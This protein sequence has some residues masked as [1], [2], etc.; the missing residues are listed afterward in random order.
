MNLIRIKRACSTGAA[1]NQLSISLSRHWSVK[2]LEVESD[3]TVF[4]NW[5][6]ACL[7][8]LCK[9]HKTEPTMNFK[10]EGKSALSKVASNKFSGA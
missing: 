7:V 8:T 4:K 10:T 5:D 6:N 3:S 2:I 1:E 9:E